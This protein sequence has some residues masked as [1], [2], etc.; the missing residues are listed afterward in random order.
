VPGENNDFCFGKLFLRLPKDH[1]SIYVLHLEVGDDDVEVV[2]LDLLDPFPARF[3]NR[4]F[5]AD[6][7]EALGHGMR[8]RLVIIDDQHADRD[9]GK[10]SFKVGSGRRHGQ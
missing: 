1:Q 7:L 2:R 10:V 3:G 8:M 6:A 4:A 5:A 9:I